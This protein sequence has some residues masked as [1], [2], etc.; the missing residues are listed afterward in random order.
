MTMGPELRRMNVERFQRLLESASD[1][2]TRD[3]IK[4][5][6]KDER[7]KPDAAYPRR[8]PPVATNRPKAG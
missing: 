8:P 4:R 2:I 3:Q 5:L 6:I 1:D 7:T